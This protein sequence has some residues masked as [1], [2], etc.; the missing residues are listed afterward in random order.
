[1]KLNLWFCVTLS[2]IE[3]AGM[4][5]KATE[6]K[7]DFYIFHTTRYST[8][9]YACPAFVPPPNNDPNMAIPRFCHENNLTFFS[10]RSYAQNKTKAPQHAQQT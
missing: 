5:I 8:K 4:A 6:L 3:T 10:T 7:A 2:G 9:P 1:V